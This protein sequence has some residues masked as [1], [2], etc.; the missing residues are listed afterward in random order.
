MLRVVIYTRYSSDLQRE[1]S[2][3][4]QI[5][6]CQQRIEQEGWILG[7]TYSD[8]AISGASMQRD[9]LRQLMDDAAN[10]SF[11]IV[12]T[13]GLDRLSRDTEHMPAIYKRLT[14]HG[15][16]IYSLT[17]GG[18]VSDL[19]IAFGGAKNAMFLKD[20]AFKV[21]RGIAG[22]VASG[23]SISRKVYGYDVV[24]RFNEQGM[25][26]RGE[27]SINEAEAANVRRIFTLYSQ[28]QSARKIAKTF[29][30]ESIPSPSG[31]QW[32]ATSINGN[33]YKGTGMLNNELY[34]GRVVWNRNSYHKDP[35]T[36]QRKKRANDQ[37]DWVTSEAPHLRIID[38]DLWDKVK[39][40]QES[41]AQKQEPQQKRRPPYLLS[42][43]LKCGSCGGGFALISRGYYGCYQARN[44]GVCK[45]RKTIHKTKIEQAVLNALEAQLLRHDLLHHFVDEYNKHLHQLQHAQRGH[46]QRAEQALKKL[47]HEKVKLVEAIKAGIPAETL[48][49]EFERNTQ[50]RDQQL[51]IIEQSHVP[52]KQTVE[53]DMTTRYHNAIRAMKDM[54]VNNEGGDHYDEGID[55]IRRLID[56]VVMTPNAETGALDIC[57]HGDLANLLNQQDNIQQGM[58]NSH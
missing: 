17:D 19:H 52:E 46:I 22:K 24:R 26:V 4:D 14:Y 43:L 53:P 16:R 7:K 6:V 34:I 2:I 56:K 29:N 23:K 3:E 47:D 15:A 18:F 50:Q 36:E 10:D 5:R 30:Q 13:E 21:K 32:M 27:R 41:L 33:R 51:H 44:K 35:D 28:G 9:A 8:F 42:Y 40:R 58:N 49:D 25:P 31:K 57:L 39:A 55:L 45:N 38:Q 54:T 20:L 12:V 11:D 1:T 48:K 37:K